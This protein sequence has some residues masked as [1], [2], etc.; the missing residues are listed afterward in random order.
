MAPVA[1]VQRYDEE[2]EICATSLLVTP[3]T[4]PVVTP[5]FVARKDGPPPGWD[6]Q[7]LW[8]ARSAT[9]LREV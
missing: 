7:P 9:A 3:P 8:A 1:V 6:P 4:S 5:A 2:P